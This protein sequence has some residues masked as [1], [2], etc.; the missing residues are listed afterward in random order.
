MT[1][2]GT[3]VCQQIMWRKQQ[4]IMRLEEARYGPREPDPASCTE[5]GGKALY[6]FGRL[7]ACSQHKGI[8]IQAASKRNMRIDAAFSEARREDFRNKLF[9]GSRTKGGMRSIL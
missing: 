9:H 8:V 7:G 5:C 6:M 2:R 4:R 3:A 1:N